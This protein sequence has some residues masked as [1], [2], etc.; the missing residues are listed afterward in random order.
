MFSF[1]IVS[2]ICSLS[3]FL[4]VTSKTK[5]NKQSVD[6]LLIKRRDQ[7]NQPGC[8]DSLHSCITT[9]YYG[10]VRGPTKIG[11]QNQWIALRHI[12]FI[13]CFSKYFYSSL[14][15]FPSFMSKTLTEFEENQKVS[16]ER[17]LNYYSSKLFFNSSDVSL[18]KS[19]LKL[20]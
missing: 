3:F 19:R 15:P 5:Q 6:I 2:A 18:K 1:F 20:S 12:I 16:Q 8:T 9:T 13:L 4:N 11:G 14:L 10:V 7:K 17:R